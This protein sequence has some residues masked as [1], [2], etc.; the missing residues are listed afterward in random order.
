MFIAHDDAR[1]LGKIAFMGLWQGRFVESES[2]FAALRAAQP[3]RIGPALGLGMV[4][5]HK[6][7]YAKAAEILE[8][9]AL[10][11]DPKD[12][13]ARAWL[14][15]VLYRDGKNEQARRYLDAV[16]ADA[17][18]EDAKKLARS[19]LDEMAAAT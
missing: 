6:G 3:D 12:D 17:S 8:T 14:G 4:H 2:I 11:M 1:L 5:A 15:L 10:A 13:H 18:A 19:I 9:Q 16:L 7:A